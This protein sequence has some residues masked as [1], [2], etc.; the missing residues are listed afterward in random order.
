LCFRPG[1]QVWNEAEDERVVLFLDV[2]RPLPRFY[3]M[4]NAAFIFLMR[5][6]PTVLGYRTKAPL[7]LYQTQGSECSDFSNGMLM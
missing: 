6:H 2:V 3:S 7:S 1:E 5:W 4:L